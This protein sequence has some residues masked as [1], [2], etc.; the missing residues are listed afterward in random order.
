MVCVILMKGGIGLW[1]LLQV[2]DG[3]HRK[4]YIVSHDRV[5]NK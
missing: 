5:G 4:F 3:I 2:F 1:I